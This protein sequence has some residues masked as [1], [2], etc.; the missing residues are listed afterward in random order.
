MSITSDSGAY[1]ATYREIR[2]AVRKVRYAGMVPEKII[3]GNFEYESLLWRLRCS[4]PTVLVGFR[5][6]S[7]RFMG[8]DVERSGED[9]GVEVRALPV[10]E[11]VTI[12]K[13]DSLAGIAGS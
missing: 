11:S 5:D 8:M 9:S 10:G 6:L 4:E 2:L 13:N 3:L 7:I 1:L 12:T